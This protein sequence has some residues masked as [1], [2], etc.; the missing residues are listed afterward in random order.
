MAK[1]TKVVRKK[2]RRNNA[3]GIVEIGEGVIYIDPRCKGKKELEI[4]IHE[5]LHILCPYLTE[6][7][8]EN[9]AADIT[10]LL[11][12]EGFRKIDGEDDEKLQDEL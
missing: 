11:W 5:G 8:V 9:T 6:E 10:R 12:G 2:L 4:L 1:I 7:T 3:N